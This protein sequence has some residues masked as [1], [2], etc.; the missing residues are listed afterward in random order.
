[1]PD[2]LE[3]AQKML[4]RHPL[5]NN[6]LGRQFA[7]LGYGI[8][9]EKRGDALKILLSMK[10]HQLA[11]SNENSGFTL[12]ETLASNGNFK[13]AMEIFGKMKK[14]TDEA[15]PCYLCEERFDFLKRLSNL[16]VDKLQEC[17]LNNF[18]VGI[19]LPIEVEEREDEFKGEFMIEHGESMRN[20]FSRSIGKKIA[21]A[22]GKTI[23]FAR[24]EV[25]ILVNP[26]TEQI[27]L[28]VN[29]LFVSGRYRKLERG[30]PQ[31]RW[32]C[33]S[34]RGNGCP[35]CK[36]TGK[37]YQES[38]EEI[39]GNPILEITQG[40]KIAFHGAGREDVDA[41]MLG[42]GRPFVIEIKKP[43][44][45]FINLRS[46][47]KMINEKAIGR[48]QVSNLRFASKEVVRKLKKSETA[49]KLY[50]VVVEADKPVSEKQLVKLQKSLAAASIKQQTPRR[51]LHR[52]AD[53]IREK[54]IYKTKVKRLMPNSFEIR[55]RCQGGLYIKE[56]VTG[57]EG[58]TVPSVAAILD[59]KA[60]PIELDVLG[61]YIAE[62]K[63]SEKI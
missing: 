29:P 52:R 39:V 32:L 35:K 27:T 24:P 8:E 10:A 5:C 44:K 34:C 41:R 43:K 59:I 37:M 28:Q 19:E 56:L 63:I 62:E 22:T 53:L 31:S 6:C 49:E 47:Q 40:E 4:E 51:V 50:R 2:I 13:I 9:N 30:I 21:E 55:I 61:V 7:L 3:K 57:D 15:K 16:A 54:Y 45:R 36:W 20:E 11:L 26:F 58:R 14:K 38:V 42:L 17:E 18:L 33:Q 25:V 23:E 1:M 60:V 46:L 48:V 12:L